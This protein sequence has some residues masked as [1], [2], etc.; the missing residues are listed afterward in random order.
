MS[1]SVKEVRTSQEMKAFL[2]LP[3][4]LYRDS[5]YWV[6]E[7]ISIEKET[8][9]PRK[10]PSYQDAEAKLFIAQKDGDVVGRIVGLDNKIANKKYNTKNLRFGW[11]ESIN[12]N[13]VSS[14]L[15]GAV[16]SWA[17]ELGMETVTGPHGFTDLDKL[18]MLIEGFDQLSTIAVYYNH[19]YYIDLVEH[20]GF[21]KEIDYW[22]FFASLPS[23]NEIPPK[24]L[25]IA[26]RVKNRSRARLI[27]FTSRRH[28]MSR[29][30]EVFKLLNETFDQLY[31]STPLSDKQISYYAK[32][33]IPLVDK[34]L[35]KVMVNR[36]DEVVGFMISMP[37]L[38]RAFRKSKGR[39]LP[40]GW[41]Y[42]LKDF[43]KGNVI[44]FYLAGVKEEYRGV[45]LDLVMVLES[46][47][48]ARKKGFLYAESNPELE[49]NK[50]IHI[51]WKSYNPRLHKKRR[52]YKKVLI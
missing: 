30:P 29:V 12:D 20:S 7:L 43:K 15:F 8:F 2:Q 40:F 25:R 28:V 23:R 51:Q 50:N 3:F 5:P 36:K 33:Y 39:L 52:I 35:F 46:I 45:G 24:L 6:P 47:R 11:F 10:N 42:I 48:S 22:E 17:K 26:E 16:F 32:K 18:G 49:T 1:V 13:R 4:T 34:E 27:E 37:N 9:N 21:T 31:G 14:A 44:D 41:Y 19:P 38:S